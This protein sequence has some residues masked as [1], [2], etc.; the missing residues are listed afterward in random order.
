[1]KLFEV[2]AQNPLW[3]GG[4]KHVLAG[5]EHY[6][7][8][9]TLPNVMRFFP[10]VKDEEG[11]GKIYGVLIKKGNELYFPMPADVVGRRKTGGDWKLLEL[12]NLGGL[13]YLPVITKTLNSYEGA[14]GYFISYQD[15]I[16]WLYGFGNFKGVRETKEFMETALKVG[17]KI[18]WD[19][20]TAEEGFLYFQERIYL[21]RDVSLVFLAE[22]VKGSFFFLGGERNL[23]EVRELCK[24]LKELKGEVEVNRFKHYKLYLLSHTYFKGEEIKVGGIPF[25]V[26]WIYS[27]GSE[28]VSGYKKPALEMLRPGSVLILRAKG[29]GKLKRLCQVEEKPPLK[30]KGV[31]RFL[32]SGWNTGILTK[33]GV[34]DE[35]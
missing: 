28:F 2:K 1:M 25:K 16:N 20:G 23:A 6:A 4:L 17:L 34:E 8:V 18:N 29:E 13:G 19:L 22:D 26:I 5:E 7:K 31:E 11:R 15:F 30:F 3:F 27:R 24:E 21:K 32:S 35:V 33:G 12:K 9:Q 10:A 14:D